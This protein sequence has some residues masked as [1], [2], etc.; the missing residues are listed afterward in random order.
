MGVGAGLALQVGGPVLQCHHQRGGLGNDR[1][2]GGSR[3][4]RGGLMP[5]YTV[6]GVRFE[7]VDADRATVDPARVD[8]T[9]FVGVAE[10]GPLDTPVRLES[11]E[12]F[13]STFGSFRPVGMLAYAVKGFFDNGGRTCHVIRVAAPE[14]ALTLAA[15]PQP[16]DRRSSVVTNAGDVAPGSAVTIREG[17]T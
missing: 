15:G 7:T 2:R 4:A 17:A 6:P 16:A 3:E 14:V 10:R 12:Q 1:D 5:V 9:A 8:I 13:T 11:W